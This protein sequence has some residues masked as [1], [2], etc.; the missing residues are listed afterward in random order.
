MHIEKVWRILLQIQIEKKREREKERE[1]VRDNIYD[2]FTL[3]FYFITL[4]VL[5]NFIYHPR[6]RQVTLLAYIMQI[7]SC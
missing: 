2:S 5:P 1:R 7:I 4:N 3:S 6:T